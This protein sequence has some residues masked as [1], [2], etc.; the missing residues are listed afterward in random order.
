MFARSLRN[1]LQELDCLVGLTAVKTE[2]ARLTLRLLNERA[3]REQGL[4]IFPA[5]RHLVFSGPAGVGKSRVAR[6]FGKICRSLGALGKGHMVVVDRADLTAASPADKAMRMQ[7]KCIAAL[8]GVLYVRNEAFLS[9]GILRSTGDLHLDAVDVMIDFMLRH[10]GRLMVVLDARPNELNYVSFHS[11]LARRFSETV[12][13]PAYDA[14]ELVQ[15]LAGKAQRL[16]LALPEGIEADLMAWITAC[17]RRSD[18]RNA[19]EM[20]DVFAQALGARA[21]RAA[22]QRRAELGGFARSDFRLA[23]RTLREDGILGAQR[24]VDERAAMPWRSHPWPQDA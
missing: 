2:I 7:A 16:G 22:R 1:E 3:Y 12:D 5:R 10:R 15:I 18:W 21:M 13:F 11:G 4:S 23:L 9:A 14:D 17:S 20:T 8:D 24:E 19:H 6:A